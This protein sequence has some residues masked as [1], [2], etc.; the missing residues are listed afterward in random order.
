[1][2]ETLE[3]QTTLSRRQKYH[4]IFEAAAKEREAHGNERKHLIGVLHE[5]H[6]RTGDAN[7]T[8]NNGGDCE[9]QASLS[10]MRIG[11]RDKK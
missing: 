10:H 6:E 4:G 11:P 3:H 8:T 9:D 7:I 5:L 2:H 1:M